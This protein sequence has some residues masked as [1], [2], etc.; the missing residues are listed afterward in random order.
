[1]TIWN[2]EDKDEQIETEY[3]HTD[4]EWGSKPKRRQKQIRIISYKLFDEKD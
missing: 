1:M 4:E 3:G 2:M